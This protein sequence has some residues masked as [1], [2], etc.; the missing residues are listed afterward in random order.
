MEFIV[1]EDD[2]KPDVHELKIEPDPCQLAVRV[3]ALAISQPTSAASSSSE[4]AQGPGLSSSYHT[5]PLCRVPSNQLGPKAREA[6]GIQV[7]A[8]HCRRPWPAHPARA[9]S[10][11]QGPVGDDVEV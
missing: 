3:A 4:E 5:Q 6:E 11:G 1:D 2:V 9:S 10:S 8:A 7:P